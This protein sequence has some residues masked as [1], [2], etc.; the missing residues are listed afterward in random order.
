M[1]IAER[2]KNMY[3]I[4]FFQT[5]NCIPIALEIEFKLQKRTKY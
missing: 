5:F 3:Y 4:D 1:A 2:G